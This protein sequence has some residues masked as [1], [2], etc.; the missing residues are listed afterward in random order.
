M[1]GK[2]EGGG[3]TLP[4]SLKVHFIQLKWHTQTERQRGGDRQRRGALLGHVNCCKYSPKAKLCDSC[5][6]K[7]NYEKGSGRGA[8]TRY[9]QVK[10]R[11]GR[12]VAHKTDI[13]PGAGLKGNLSWLSAID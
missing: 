11:A 8:C 1:C 7:T 5:K 2:G 3:G 13:V 10:G 4:A 9:D 12:F 6:N